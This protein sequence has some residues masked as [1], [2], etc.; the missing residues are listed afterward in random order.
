MG[1]LQLTDRDGLMADVAELGVMLGK[2]R[3]AYALSAL[4]VK[5][6][7]RALPAPKKGRTKHYLRETAWAIT[8][9]YYATGGDFESLCDVLAPY[10]DLYDTIEKSDY[11]VWTAHIPGWDHRELGSL[12]LFLAG[13][14]YGLSPQRAVDI[15]GL[16]GALAV[17]S[18]GSE[19]MDTVVDAILEAHAHWIR[20]WLRRER[21]ADITRRRETMGFA[22][23]YAAGYAFDLD[24]QI[25]LAIADGAVGPVTV[26]RDNSEAPADDAGGAS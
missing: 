13:P 11:N 14:D 24:E 7:S 2:R 10:R 12:M 9:L 8:S 18:L 15:A 6:Q 26:E 1:E 23:A 20:R 19:V 4:G 17:S 3:F 5:A 21:D 22:F 25:A 16:E